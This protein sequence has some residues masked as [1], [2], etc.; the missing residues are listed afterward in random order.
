MN[1]EKKDFEAIWRKMNSLTK[2]KIQINFENYLTFVQAGEMDVNAIY[3][4]NDFENFIQVWPFLQTIPL[5]IVINIPKQEVQ[6]LNKENFNLEMMKSL[7][8]FLED[9]PIRI[10]LKFQCYLTRFTCNNYKEIWTLAM[11]R[12]I[13]IDFEDYLSFDLENP[14]EEILI[15]YKKIE[16]VNLMEVHKFLHIDIPLNRIKIPYQVVRIS[17]N[18]NFDL[19]KS[20]IELI[21]K[22][23]ITINLKFQFNPAKHCSCENYKEIWDKMNSITNKQKIQIDFEDYLSIVPENPNEEISIIYKK[24]E[25]WN[26]MEVSKFL[27]NIPENRIKIPFQEVQ[28]SENVNFYLEVFKSFMDLIGKLPITINLKFHLNPAT[29]FNYKDYE[30]IWRKM[31]S[32]TNKQKIQID[33]EDYLS[34]VPENPTEES[35]MI[36]KSSRFQ[37]LFSLLPFL[38]QEIPQTQLIVCKQ[39]FVFS[40][41][42]FKEIYPIMKI[43]LTKV[44]TIE[45]FYF[46][47]KF[48][49]SALDHFELF[50]LNSLFIEF[51]NFRKENAKDLIEVFSK[52]MGLK[53]FRLNISHITVPCKKRHRCWFAI[54]E[55]IKSIFASNP[56]LKIFKLKVNN[57]EYKFEFEIIKEICVFE[58]DFAE[59]HENILKHFPIQNNLV[60]VKIMSEFIQENLSFLEKFKYLTE[61]TYGRHNE[62]KKSKLAN[63]RLRFVFMAWNLRK[64]LQFVFKRKLIG[65]EILMKFI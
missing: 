50:P 29:H 40:E 25:S 21:G 15:I 5:N 57:P 18:V 59:N 1:L 41:K 65:E 19:F 8:G 45:K 61:L 2:I 33:F 7:M 51:S 24:I 22:L 53:E 11:K 17:E 31:N 6:I 23:P 36:L 58:I 14:T 9:S 49:S 48:N 63:F 54:N 39:E 43:D 26:L 35:K 12:K 30:E 28:I 42:N 16:S 47:C 46:S 10:N 13:R 34:I 60:K 62:I 52:F 44:F 32:L 56:N 27:H 3:K 37:F 20:F 64:K 38:K 55:L 4:G